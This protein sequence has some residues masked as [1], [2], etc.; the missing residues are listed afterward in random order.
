MSDSLIDPADP[1]ERQA[2][3]LR[4]I[5]EV[6]MRRVE[7]ATDD[8]GAAYAQFQR[9]VLLE[10]QVRARTR[11]L[12]HALDLLNESNA[13]LA[14]ANRA[15][16]TARA[17]LANAIETLQEGFA[18][19]D[20]SDHLV[21]FNS[22]FVMQ[23]PD[24]RD[25]LC[26]GLRFH[27]Y[28]EAVSRSRYLTLPEGETPEIWASRRRARHRDN[29]HTV[30]NIS[31]LGHRWVQV[32][33]HRT[34]DGKTVILQ[35]DITDIMRSERRERSRML[36]DQARLVRATLDHINQG[37]CI[38]DSAHRLVGWNRKVGAMLSIPVAQF[39][40]G[41]DFDRLFGQLAA[42]RALRFDIAPTELLDWVHHTDRRPPLR[43]GLGRGETLMLDVLAE[44][45]PDRGFVISV[46]DITAERRA[47]GALAEAKAHFEQRALARTLALE[48]ALSVA[49]RANA[50]KSRFVAAASHDLLQPLSAARLYV[51]SIAEDA[52]LP[53]HREVL[54]RAET[55]LESVE[56]ILEA[57]LD[58]STLDSGQAAVAPGP[59]P[60]RELYTRLQTDFAPHAALKGLELR[61]LPRDLT[62]RTDPG[63][64]R[65]ILQNLVSNAIRYTG[66]G[67]V[68]VG[69]R[70]QGQSLRLEVWDT[71]PGIAEEDQEAIFREF[72]RL[73]ARAS[74]SEG[75]GLGLAI[76]ERACA[77]L[78]H[79]LGLWSRP[80]HG[81]GFFVTVPLGETA[82]PKPAPKAPAA[83]PSPGLV[84]LLIEAD[85]EIRR[86]LPMLVGKWG[87]DVIDVADIDEAL[88]LLAE[89]DLKPDAALIE[90]RHGAQ[91]GPGHGLGALS[92]IETRY[93]PIPACIVS[94]ERSPDLAAACRAR[95]AELLTKPL[96]PAALRAF[97]AEIAQRERA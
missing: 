94:A 67:R 37:V 43:F 60:L 30:I 81:S 38:F 92:L 12:E 93:G 76:V 73:N 52:T 45:M 16:E 32:S 1:P 8:G 51:S 96:S 86:A 23:M 17:D 21:L 5:A 31:L 74:A 13:R 63:Y 91:T 47:A 89:I 57:L 26:P 6:L 82:A 83:E 54:G 56:Q 27:D 15:T 88:T 85:P 50:S 36:D 58:I 14:E 22:R 29:P 79:P 10:D 20:Q 42:D 78:G 65:R 2:E 7:Q 69:A 39:R 9:A 3:K 59:V 11:D 80:G 18:L 33:D 4:E 97:F 75:M 34:E 49:E 19:F 90:H 71:G 72:H 84:A 55:A 46:S 68:L 61:V 28:V 70:R 40:L 25:R 53:A 62:L 35:T 48:D 95:G 77:R 44:E 64:I 66:C 87:V 24:V 41:A